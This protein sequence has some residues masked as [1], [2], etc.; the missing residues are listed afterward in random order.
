MHLS[1]FVI[2]LFTHRSE[3]LK[4]WVIFFSRCCFGLFIFVYFVRHILCNIIFIHILHKIIFLNI[5]RLI[6]YAHCV[7]KYLF[8]IKRIRIV[9]KIYSFRK[10]VCISFKLYFVFMWLY[11]TSIKCFIKCKSVHC[12]IILEHFWEIIGCRVLHSSGC[13]QP[14]LTW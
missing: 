11:A 2:V 10:I 12:K 7:G 1:D 3:F 5:F 14:K 13:T 8:T 4:I 9:S 6:T